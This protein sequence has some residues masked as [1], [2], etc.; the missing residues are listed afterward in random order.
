MGVLLITMRM[1]GFQEPLSVNYQFLHQ[2]HQQD[3]IKNVSISDTA[4]CEGTSAR[5]VEN[6]EVFNINWSLSRSDS[7]HRYRFLDFILPG[8]KFVELSKKYKVSIATQTSL[9]WL[10]FIVN[11]SQ[12]WTGPVSLAVFVGGEEFL[13]AKLYIT[14]LRECFPHVKDQISF[15]LAYSMDYPPSDDPKPEF[16]YKQNCTNPEAVLSDLLKYQ[17]PRTINWKNNTLYPQNHLRNQARRNCQTEYVYVTDVDIVP[18]IG[19]ADSL[20]AF[21][22]KSQC[23][24]LCAYV[25]PVYELDEKVSFPRNKAEM[26]KMAKKRLARPYHQMVYSPAQSS[27]DYKR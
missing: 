8:N 12:H 9:E 7:K 26:L 2:R 1:V 17:S 13:L 4:T 24:R 10:H 6:L 16:K 5:L 14:Y 11:L 18:C 27:T 15:H 3:F 22:R 23:E 19:M 21:L 25:I 20:D